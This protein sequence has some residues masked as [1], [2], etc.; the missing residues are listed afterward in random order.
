MCM[1]FQLPGF[2]CMLPLCRNLPDKSSAISLS[3]IIHY[4]SY[5]LLYVNV[6]PLILI[7]CNKSYLVLQLTVHS[8]SKHLSFVIWPQ[9]K[10]FNCPCI[11]WYVWFGDYIY[12]AIKNSMRGEKCIVLNSCSV[13]WQ[14]LYSSS[15]LMTK[16]PACPGLVVPRVSFTPLYSCGCRAAVHHCEDLQSPA[17]GGKLYSRSCNLTNICCSLY[18]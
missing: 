5:M 11:Q 10:C 12:I 7:A 8:P 15:Q 18:G 16:G 1:H 6:K 3:R 13:V 2:S 9:M 14:Q 17:G 4:L